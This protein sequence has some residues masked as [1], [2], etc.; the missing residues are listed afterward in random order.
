[1][2]QAL[3]DSILKLGL[4]DEATL[5]QAAQLQP[6]TPLENKL[7]DMG[8]ISEEQLLQAYSDITALPIWDGEGELSDPLPFSEEFLVYNNILPINKLDQ[9]WFIIDNAQDDGLA[10]LLRE[11][12]P[13]STV[14]IYPNSELS[15]LIDKHFQASEQQSDEEQSTTKLPDIEHLKDLALEAPI[16]RLVNDILSHAVKLGASDIH[17]EPSRTRIELRYRIDGVLV[18][19]AAP[20]FDEYPAIVSRIKILANLDI[21]E[22]RLP[23]DGRIRTKSNGRDIDIRVSTIPT[24]HGE[25]IVMRILDQKKQVLSLANSGLSANITE[26]FKQQLKRSHGIILVTGPTGSGKTTT[27][28]SAL[29][30]I[31]DGETKII[32]VEDPVEYEIPGITQIPVN[33]A[34]GMHFIAALRSILRHDPDVIFIGE[35]RDRETAEIAIQSSLTGHLVLSTLHT[36]SALGAINRFLDMGIPDYLLA[37]SLNA[38]SAQRLVRKLCD[39]CKQANQIDPLLAQHYNIPVDQTIYEAV[40]CKKCAHTGYKGRLPIAEFKVVDGELRHAILENPSLDNLIAAAAIN[41]PSNLISDG[42]AKV[43]EGLTSIDEV[44]R[45]AG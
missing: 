32:T 41:D 18:S 11:T 19:R 30:E 43:V 6:E 10:D 40:G 22:R 45:T 2:T 15:Q 17:L 12:F 39:E 37:S 36:N 27:L 25:D 7:L 44:M 35:I 13:E 24:P 23:Q 9:Q 26:I 4:L 21:A 14:A 5:R 42:I 38:V 20:N 3:E 28:Y 33:D 34:I 8:V 31:I 29:Q 16:I 1:M